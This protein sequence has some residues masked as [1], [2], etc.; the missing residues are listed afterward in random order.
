MGEATPG[1]LV[2]KLGG[3]AASKQDVYAGE[4]HDSHVRIIFPM[5]KLFS[6]YTFLP[7]LYFISLR[8]T[9]SYS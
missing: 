6:V 3:V 2:Q 4:S 5:H 7:I 8:A 9:V 1:A